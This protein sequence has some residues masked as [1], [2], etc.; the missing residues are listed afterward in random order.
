[1][2][3]LRE[4]FAGNKAVQREVQSHFISKYKTYILTCL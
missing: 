4:K 2:D 3:L 1:M